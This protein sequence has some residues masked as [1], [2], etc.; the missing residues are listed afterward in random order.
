MY[1]RQVL[2]T[3][4]AR[5]ADD[6]GRHTTTHRSLHKLPGGGVILDSPGM[7]EFQIT[8]ADR[9]VSYVFEDIE[10]LA[11]LCKFNDCQHQQEP[12]C[13]VQ[14]AIKRGELDEQRLKSYFKLKREDRIN[15]ETIAERHARSR[16]FNKQVKANLAHNP[17]FNR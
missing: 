13:A 8:D 16:Q 17:K 14:A 4:S 2:S 7:R 1:K 6:K 11:R 12:G 3:Q 15:T 9:G 5:D 10:E